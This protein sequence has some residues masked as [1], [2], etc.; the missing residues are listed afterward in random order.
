M[1]ISRQIALKL[2]RL[3]GDR[4]SRNIGWLTAAEG[5]S[6]VGRILAAIILAR[7][8]DVAAFGVAAIAAPAQPG[9]SPTGRPPCLSDAN[10]SNRARKKKLEFTK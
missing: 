1:S 3:R 8:L 7:Q 5:I 4:F 10:R 2:G 9:R 6:R